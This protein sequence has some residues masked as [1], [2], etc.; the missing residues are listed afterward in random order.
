MTSEEV[1][2]T[3]KPSF[4]IGDNKRPSDVDDEYYNLEKT[5]FNIESPSLDKFRHSDEID[6]YSLLKPVSR[7]S[8]HAAFSEYKFN[9]HDLASE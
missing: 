2:E 1:I 3:M 6:D 7:K 5:H 4:K 9:S 8:G